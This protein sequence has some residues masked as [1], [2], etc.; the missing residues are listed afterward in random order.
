MPT[1]PPASIAVEGG[2]PVVGDL[3]SF[4]WQNGGSDSPWLPGTPIHV[5]AGERLVLTMSTPVAIANWQ[6]NYIPA[7]DL[8]ST[9]PVGLG[10]GAAEPISFMSPPE[11]RWSV[12]VGMWF[13]G[14]GSAAYYWSVEVE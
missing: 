5:G 7:D 14:G 11:G 13:A 9:T 1:P 12:H 8:Q 10:E 4:T 6:A 2:D 3:G